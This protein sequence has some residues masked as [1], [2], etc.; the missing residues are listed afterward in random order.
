LVLLEPLAPDA[1]NVKLPVR[2]FVESYDKPPRAWTVDVLVP[3][4]PEAQ[5]S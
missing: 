1:A 3:L 5:A 2:A 4:E